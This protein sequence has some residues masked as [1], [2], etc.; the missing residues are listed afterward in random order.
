MRTAL[1]CWLQITKLPI[2]KSSNWTTHYH[3]NKASHY[4]TLPSNLCKI[5]QGMVFSNSG[6]T[7]KDGFATERYGLLLKS[8]KDS[9]TLQIVQLMNLHFSA[10]GFHLVFFLVTPVDFSNILIDCVKEKISSLFYSS[11][12]TSHQ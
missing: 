2:I 10:Q 7:T 8:T 1:L 5:E 6:M 3:K 4:L 11:T 9:T 12:F